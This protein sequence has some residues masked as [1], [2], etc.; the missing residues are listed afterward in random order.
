MFNFVLIGYFGRMAQGTGVRFPLLISVM[1]T[2]S[3]LLHDK[4]T[5]AMMA[6]SEIT[7]LKYL[8]HW[9]QRVLGGS[10]KLRFPSSWKIGKKIELVF[11][12]T[13]T[14][15]GR[16]WSKG[17]GWELESQKKAQR[18]RARGLEHQKAIFFTDHCL[19]LPL[20]LFLS[21]SHSSFSRTRTRTRTHQTHAHT[22][23]PTLPWSK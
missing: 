17:I 6:Y 23:T 21:I 16:N 5:L 14:L 1:Y 8:S 4:N 19:L 15:L 12:H 20:S 2:I 11:W 13:F 7:Y 3:L 18:E 9:A 10:N 22:P